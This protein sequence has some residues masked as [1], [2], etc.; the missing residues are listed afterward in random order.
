MWKTVEAYFSTEP[1]DEQKRWNDLRQTLG[2]DK[3]AETF[4]FGLFGDVIESLNDYD[5]LKIYHLLPFAG[6]TRDQPTWFWENIRWLE[7]FQ[8][9]IKLDKKYGPQVLQDAGGTPAEKLLR[10]MKPK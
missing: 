6:G 9:F 3:S 10:K 4:N 1:T 5:R 2:V 7:L 8:E